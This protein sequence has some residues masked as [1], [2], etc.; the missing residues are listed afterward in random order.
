MNGVYIISIICS[1]FV[2]I[3]FHLFI[4]HDI[5]VLLILFLDAHL[6]RTQSFLVYLKIC[7]FASDGYLLQSLLPSST[8]LLPTTE[9]AL[10]VEWISESWDQ[11][12]WSVLHF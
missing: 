6:N 1:Y 8:L 12:L 9:W 4:H 2:L 11:R 5:C 7:T 10:F 3:L